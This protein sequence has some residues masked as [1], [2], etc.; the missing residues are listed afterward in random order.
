M[1]GE[2]N[3]LSC[4]A[5]YATVKALAPLQG[6][7]V[8]AAGF[9]AGGVIHRFDQKFIHEPEAFGLQAPG[10]CTPLAEALAG[11]RA[12]I[13]RRP[14]KRKIIVVLTDGAPD[15]PRSAIN[16]RL[17]CEHYGI[18]MY[19]LGIQHQAVKN[20]FPQWRVINTLSDL[21]PELLGLLGQQLYQQVA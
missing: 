2:R 7:S 4:D 16:Q 13:N 19:G 1:Q 20:I 17:I 8:A 10:D 15:N 12:M 21:T 11:V 3:T 18:E 14:E 6:V 9:P 5:L